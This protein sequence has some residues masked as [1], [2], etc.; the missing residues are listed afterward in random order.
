MSCDVAIITHAGRPCGA[1][2]DIVLAEAL[3]ELG[4]RARFVVWNDRDADWSATPIAI[5]RSTWDYHLH[6]AA[7]REWL[8]TASQYT[9][10]VNPVGLITWNTD[11]RYLLALRE[12]GVAIV[13]TLVIEHHAMLGELQQRIDHERWGD[14]VVKPAIGAS[15]FGAKRFGVLELADAVAHAEALAATGAVLVQPFQDAVLT[16]RERSLVM[17]GGVFSHAFTKPAFDPGAAAGLRTD[18]AHTPSE[19]ELVLADRVLSAVPEGPTYARVDLVPGPSGPLL[20]ELELI[21]PH[22]ALYDRPSAARRLAG[23]LLP[24]E[25]K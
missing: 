13:P 6:P 22:L 3:R 17:L 12:S 9:R 11:K 21:E 18:V 1:P 14:I 16:E 25:T 23:L 7:W 2:D 8:G 20:M 24:L 19:A 4:A 10:L 5:V 15:A